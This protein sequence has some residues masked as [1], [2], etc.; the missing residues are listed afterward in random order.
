MLPSAVVFGPHVW[1]FRDTAERLIEAGA[2]IQVTEVRE[3]E[4]TIQRLLADKGE[5]QQLG[6]AA[7]Q[8]VVSQQGAT[9]RT[10]DL[11]ECLKTCKALAGPDATFA[12]GQRRGG[13]TA[14]RAARYSSSVR[15]T[16]SPTVRMASTPEVV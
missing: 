7:Q 16:R 12:L 10:I 9:E 6:A 13:I 15:A 3:L 5:R 4:T 1:N 2:A 11:I 14:L 8:L